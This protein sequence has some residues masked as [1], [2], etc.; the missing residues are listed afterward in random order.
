MTT[1]RKAKTKL[2][3]HTA[4]VESIRAT[5][6]EELSNCVPIAAKE[7]EFFREAQV[8]GLLKKYPPRDKEAAAERRL[9][10]VS[11]FIDTLCHLAGARCDF[12]DPDHFRQL[13]KGALSERDLVLLRARSICHY[14]LGPFDTEEWFELCKHGPNSTLGVPFADSGCS[15]KF[16]PPWT[17]TEA[18]VGLFEHYLR[19]DTLLSKTLGHSCP[20]LRRPG[21][22]WLYVDLVESSK[23]TTVPKNEKTDR[24]I[25]I[26]PT[27]N[28]FLQQG[29]GRYMAGKL[30]PFSVDIQF[31]QDVHR[32]MAFKSS[33]T[34]K[35]ATIDFSSASDCVG[36]ELLRFL[37]PPVWFETVERVRCNTVNVD[38]EIVP[39]PCIATMGNATTFVLETLVFYSL[40]VACTMKRS[41]SLIPEWDDFRKVSVFG[42]DCIV[43]VEHASL[44]MA[45][46]KSVGFIVNEDKSFVDKLDPFRESCG[47]DFFGGYNVRPTFLGG[48]RSDKPS[49]LRAWLY[50]LW[51]TLSKRLKSSLGERNYAYSPTLQLLANQISRHNKEI[52]LVSEN[53]PDDAGLKFW[54]DWDRLSRLFTSPVASVLIDRN[55]TL[56]YK[57]FVTSPPKAGFLTPEVEMWLRLKFP[58]PNGPFRPRARIPH[59]TVEKPKGLGY[60]VSWATSFDEVLLESVDPPLERLIRAQMTQKAR[61]YSD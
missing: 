54:G 24:T 37:L 56:K 6:E 57:R 58:V 1:K 32:E 4:L 53:D 10:A 15:R 19:Y 14:I 21:G 40:A 55:G 50:V 44:F 34:R 52:F 17:A 43:P 9:A 46:C 30:V 29:L 18:S 33:I 47:A 27:L 11:K 61:D 36:T 39:L 45:V 8:N 38:G 20:D 31:Q 3:S 12:P 2:F 42:D 48:P 25:A 5:L 41:L 51:N 13:P 28:M 22:I 7:W 60:V 16:L 26:E 23:L 49:C 59:F 35:H